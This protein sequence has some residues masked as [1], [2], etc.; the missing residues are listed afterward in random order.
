MLSDVLT[1]NLDI[2]FCGTAKGKASARLGYYYAAPGNQFYSILHK[3]GLTKRLL[4]PSDCYLIGDYNIGLTDLVHSQSGNDDV[5][6]HEN[7]DVVSF[8]QK[9]AKFKPRYVAF[10]GKKSA[11]YALGFDGKT[12]KVEYGLQEQMI[13]QSRIY[14]LPSTSGSARKYWNEKYWQE[15]AELIN[16]P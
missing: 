14:V 4:L 16:Q 10:N 11:A 8:K 13:H 1:Y 15:L 5:L 7:Y 2:V 12:Q 3:T 6:A 9:I